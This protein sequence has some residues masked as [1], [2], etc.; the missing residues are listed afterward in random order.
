MQLFF[1]CVSII[2]VS[3]MVRLSDLQ[4]IN[5]FCNKQSILPLHEQKSGNIDA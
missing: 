2:P 3:I 5:L 1:N 4:N